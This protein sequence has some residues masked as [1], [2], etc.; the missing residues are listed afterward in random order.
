MVNHLVMQGRMV[1]DPELKETNSGAKV[2]NFRIAWSEKYKD[3]E[4]NE[5]ENKCFLE[6]K[7][8]SGQAE[9]ISKYFKKGQE[10][11]VE[12]KLNTEEWENQ[13]G[14]KRSKIVLLVS[15]A[16]F[17]GSKQS[18]SGDVQ[19]NMTPVNMDGELPF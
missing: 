4:N 8:F 17:C 11:A 6:C 1:A 14:Q 16:H 18:S 10:I 5:K 7:T 3:R 2:L 19:P 9:F 15:N 12:G 13:D